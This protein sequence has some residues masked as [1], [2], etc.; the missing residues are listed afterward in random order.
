MPFYRYGKL[1]IAGIAVLCL[2][3]VVHLFRTGY[4]LAPYWELGN[5]IADWLFDFLS[6]WAIVLSASMT[7]LLAV[8]AFVTLM[9]MSEQRHKS[10]QP[11]LQIGKVS[12][13]FEH[14]LVDRSDKSD[15][16]PGIELHLTNVGAGPALGVK[17][18]AMATTEF[19]QE[20][21][22]A[23]LLRT[24]TSK[25]YFK[26]PRHAGEYLKLYILQ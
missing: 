9:A 4:V 10:I 17:I 21:D 8:A 26:L 7:L 23:S 11:S 20:D 12:L 15:L 19:F 3:I 14:L 2:A 22:Q 5:I 24:Q 6:S 1:F 16:T 25:L 18:S 13:I